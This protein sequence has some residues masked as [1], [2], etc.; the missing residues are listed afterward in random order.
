MKNTVKSL[1]T[2]ILLVL[3][4]FPLFG[5]SIVSFNSQADNQFL[6]TR[7]MGKTIISF[8]TATVADADRD[9]STASDI[10][11]AEVTIADMEIDLGSKVVNSVVAGMEFATYDLFPDAIMPNAFE[12]KIGNDI[13]LSADLRVYDIFLAAAF[14]SIDSALKL[15]VLNVS[16]DT[17][18]ILDPVTLA[19]L[20]DLSEG[21]DFN[22]ILNSTNTQDIV[23]SIESYST[24]SGIFSGTF[25]DITPI[26]EPLTI[27]LFMVALFRFLIKRKLS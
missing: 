6:I 16:V 10:I 11:G 8:D 23:D 4:S 7:E 20:A 3:L 26:P 13:V 15:N 27:V 2:L 12:M 18:N 1:G 9:G 5:F 22:I 17:T 21:G 24:V 25:S 14:G 19:L